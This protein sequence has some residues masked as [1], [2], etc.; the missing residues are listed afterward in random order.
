MQKI[1]IIDYGAGNFASVEKAIDYAGAQPLRITSPAQLAQC[2]RLILPGVGAAGE[3]LNALQ[4]HD[5]ISALTAQVCQKGT[6]YLGICLGMQL[7]S[8]KLYEFGEHAGFGW[9]KG[10]VIHL[11]QLLEKTAHVPHMGWNDVTFNAQASHF[12]SPVNRLR[13]FYFAHSYTLRVANPDVIA[14]TVHYGVPLVAAVKFN[15]IFATQF[16]PEKSQA[17]GNHLIQAFLNW[18]P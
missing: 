6:P 11:Q 1:G 13:Y 16:H 7:L 2:D 17:A 3:A 9:I 5:L 8:E 15:N 10:E 14:A 12:A 4:A 18:K